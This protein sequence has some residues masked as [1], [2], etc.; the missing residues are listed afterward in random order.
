MTLKHTQYSILP[1]HSELEN[2]GPTRQDAVNAY[3]RFMG[4]LETESSALETLKLKS[5]SSE[6]LTRNFWVVTNDSGSVIAGVGVA[7]MA[8]SGVVHVH[9]A[10][11]SLADG[12]QG[13]LE[14]CISVVKSWIREN[15]NR[16][17][18]GGEV[19]LRI[20][21]RDEDSV[22]DRV[23]NKNGFSS[24]LIVMIL[25]GPGFVDQFVDYHLRKD[26]DP[27]VP[28]PLSTEYKA[29]LEEQ[30]LELRPFILTEHGPMLYLSYDQ[31]YG[32]QHPVTPEEFLRQLLM[33]AG[34]DASMCYILWKKDRVVGAVIIRDFATR[35]AYVTF[36]WVSPEYQDSEV[37]GLLMRMAFSNL[38]ERGFR[39]V[40]TR[41][42]T[43]EAVE[44][45]KRGGMEK[46]KGT[47]TWECGVQ[48]GTQE[49]NL[50]KKTI[51]TTQ[52]TVTNKKT[53]VR[54]TTRVEYIRCYH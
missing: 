8:G 15:R 35:I 1:E 18:Y 4:G 27:L 23:L 41:V 36:A 54:V 46:L 19:R 14:H 29:Y 6:Y 33:G 12:Y 44:H 48:L 53:V 47:K 42:G 24:Y 30:G 45:F 5:T 38:A 25:L 40:M 28:E 2:F 7:S 49:V 51:K 34:Y 39:Y 20:Q 9:V 50:C 16:F 11:D 26:F 10:A 52:T 13:V 37:D 32:D 3:I 22:G 17:G 31:A 43:N 21:T